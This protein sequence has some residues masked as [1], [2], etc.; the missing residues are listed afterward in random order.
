MK[1]TLAGLIRRAVRRRLRAHDDGVSVALASLPP[2]RRAIFEAHC[3]AG[4]SFAAIAVDHATTVDVVEREIIAA[5]VDTR[6][7]R[8]DSV[9]PG[10]RL[11]RTPHGFRRG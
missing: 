10:S 4:K 8:R 1:F 2:P 7:Q 6:L 3:L 11:V 9:S 5:L